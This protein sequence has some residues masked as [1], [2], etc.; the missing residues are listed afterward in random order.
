MS[1]ATFTL[2]HFIPRHAGGSGRLGN[3]LPA[4]AEC[5]DRKGGAIPLPARVTTDQAGETTTSIG[6]EPASSPATGEETEPPPGVP[7]QAQIVA[8]AGGIE[9]HS[10]TSVPRAFK[11]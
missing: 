3:L 2:D 11:S 5:N 6:T 8:L 1:F 9:P 10:A 4:C 7:E